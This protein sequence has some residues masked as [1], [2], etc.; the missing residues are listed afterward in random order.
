MAEEYLLKPQADDEEKH[1]FALRLH[2][3]KK[4]RFSYNELALLREREMVIFVWW[5]QA[6]HQWAKQ[7]YLNVVNGVA[8]SLLVHTR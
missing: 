8:Q 6:W 4:L 5:L 3:K 7:A 2:H 1:S